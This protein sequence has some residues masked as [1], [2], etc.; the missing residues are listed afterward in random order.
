MGYDGPMGVKELI[1]VHGLDIVAMAR[2]AAEAARLETLI[3]G[4][5]PV[6]VDAYARRL[7]GHATAD[8]PYIGLAREYGVG[9]ADLSTARIMELGDTA[10]AP[11][12]PPRSGRLAALAVRTE[13]EQAYSACYAALIHGCGHF[14][15]EPG[16]RTVSFSW[17]T[18]IAAV[19]PRQT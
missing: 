18:I 2:A 16:S 1:V 12:V 5:D 15:G 6:L 8:V 11:A 3:A 4:R 13:E 17:C 10:V 19:G 9:S 7:M 14:S